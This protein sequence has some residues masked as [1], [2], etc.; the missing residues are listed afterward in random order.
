MSDWLKANSTGHL[1]MFRSLLLQ[2]RK[3]QHQIRFEFVPRLG[4]WA[5]W[6]RSVCVCG[7]CVGH[8]RCG[9]CVTGGGRAWVNVSVV[10]RRMSEMRVKNKRDFRNALLIFLHDRSQMRKCDFPHCSGQ[11]HGPWTWRQWQWP[12]TA[13]RRC[14]QW[15]TNL[16]C[17]RFLTH[18]HTHA[19]VHTGTHTHRVRKRERNK[20]TCTKT[21]AQIIFTICS[22]AFLI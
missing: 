21:D 22:N 4:N 14:V 8:V 3:L 6:E 10:L 20:Y 7:V 11:W 12:P 19:Q 5:H 13:T 15:P 2:G 16:M 9:V 18:T 17:W 1:R